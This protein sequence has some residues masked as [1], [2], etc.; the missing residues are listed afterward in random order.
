M[1]VNL[2]RLFVAKARQVQSCL[3]EIVF[4]GRKNMEHIVRN[5]RKRIE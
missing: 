5:V 2:I 1:G 3:H 4:A